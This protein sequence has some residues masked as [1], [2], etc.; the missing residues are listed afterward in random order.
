[1]VLTV[2]GIVF[3]VKTER[4]STA[5]LPEPVRRV[6]VEVLEISPR[7]YT[8]WV[9]AYSTVVPFR[10]GTVG[11]QVTGP[12][13][14]LALEIEPGAAV[15]TN[16]ELARIED[17]R[18]RLSL[19]KAK[20]ALGKLEALLEIEENE[21]ERRA[22]IYRIAK[23]RLTLAKSEYE[24]NQELFEKELISQQT[25]ERAENQMELRRSEF[26]NA[27]SGIQ[28]RKAR[29]QSIQADLTAAGAEIDRLQ[30]DLADT[31]VRAPFDG[32]IGDRF[33]ELGDQVTPGRKMFTVLDI[34][35]VKVVARIPSEFIGRIEPGAS[36]KVS[37]RAY[38]EPVF[39]GIVIHV[40][41]EA[42]LT[43]RTF[44]V[45]IK[46]TNPERPVLL[47]G[48]FARVRIPV[49][50]VEEALLVPRE[51]ILEDDRGTFLYVI[52]AS[53]DTAERRDLRLGNLGP[54]EALVVDGVSPG[55]SV[56]IRGQERLHNG[57]LVEWTATSPIP[58]PP[59]E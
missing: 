29:I 13:A 42:D 36:V 30:E 57:A 48:M 54:E 49:M 18:Y 25:L 53:S 12:I 8:Q 39:E 10:K 21:N 26:E 56:V 22:T 24:R 32:V 3:L 15:R 9:E 5:R 41:P 11:A 19:Q 59:A 2:A 31:I 43:N 14:E 58:S 45:E 47:P 6:S 33:V 50:D 28:S 40:H 34:A 23:Q 37:T 27:R 46:V 7:P 44:A 35:S 20:A 17:T 38:S 16:Q 51:A 55:D 4:E 1:M 52:D